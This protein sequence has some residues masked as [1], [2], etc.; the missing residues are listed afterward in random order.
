[1]LRGG[2]TW[3]FLRRGRTIAAFCQV[4]E[5]FIA[6]FYLLKFYFLYHKWGVSGIWLVHRSTS[7]CKTSGYHH[8]GAA[9]NAVICDYFSHNP[10]IWSK[11]IPYL[12]YKIWTKH[13]IKNEN[14]HRVAEKISDFSYKKIFFDFFSDFFDAFRETNLNL[15]LLKLKFYAKK[16]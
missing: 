8:L 11:N 4:P 14:Q 12:I 6:F 1:M 16:S 10:T 3:N 9:S 5:Q 15:K 2:F 7:I 13:R